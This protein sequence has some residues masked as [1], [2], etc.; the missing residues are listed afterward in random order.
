MSSGDAVATYAYDSLLN[1]YCC[2]AIALADLRAWLSG[3]GLEYIVQSRHAGPTRPRLYVLGSALTLCMFRPPVWQQLSRVAALVQRPPR[4]ALGRAQRCQR[5]AAHM[6]GDT[7]RSNIVSNPDE[8]VQVIY[9]PCVLVSYT[10]HV[11]MHS[12]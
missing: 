6:V 5:T 4:Q 12:L 8:A 7:W 2:A 1:N 11:C 9:F 10:Q 3:Q